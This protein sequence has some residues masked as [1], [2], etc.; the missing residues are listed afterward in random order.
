MLAGD[1]LLHH[2]MT[3]HGAPGNASATQRRRAYA[4]RWTGDDVVYAPREGQARITI[5]EPTCRV[6]EPIDG[7]VF[8]CLWPR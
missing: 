1:C 6:G 8:P 5:D 3:V 7:A 4:T 2:S